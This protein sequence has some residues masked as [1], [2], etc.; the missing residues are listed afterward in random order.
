MILFPSFQN[1]KIGQVDKFWR[2]KISQCLLLIGNLIYMKKRNSKVSIIVKGE[3]TKRGAD[4]YAYL[5]G[6]ARI[7]EA[8]SKIMLAL[9]RIISH[10]M[11]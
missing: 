11:L 7:I 9:S 3:I 1:R 10:F 4:R 2:E 5:N 6:I 8:C